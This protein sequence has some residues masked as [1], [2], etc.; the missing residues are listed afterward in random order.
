MGNKNTPPGFVERRSTPRT[1]TPLFKVMLTLN[2]IGWVSLVV[3]LILFILP[4][5]TLSVACKAIGVWKG[6]IV[7]R[8][9]M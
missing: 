7:G 5:P 9:N 8:Q 4:D 2:V 3:A 6:R 1:Q